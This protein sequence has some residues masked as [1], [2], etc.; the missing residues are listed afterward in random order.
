MKKIKSINTIAL[1]ITILLALIGF[2]DNDEF[3][4]YAG[5]SSVITAFI[6]LITWINA[7]ISGIYLYN[8]VVNKKPY[9]IYLFGLLLFL[10]IWLV[11]ELITISIL[12]YI[13]RVLSIILYIYLSILIYS[14][15][16]D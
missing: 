9:K 2:S 8:N 14:K 7:V 13:N 6:P 1:V 10:I 3:L 12:R 5:L 11:D 15:K 16:E 4:L